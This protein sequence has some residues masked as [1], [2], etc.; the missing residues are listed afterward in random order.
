[1]QVNTR[2]LYAFAQSGCAGG[3]SVCETLC[4]VLCVWCSACGALQRSHLWHTRALR[5]EM[6]PAHYAVTA[7][8]N[9]LYTAA[10]TDR[11]L[12]NGLYTSMYSRDPM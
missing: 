2:C 7:A 11:Y 9:T 10:A 12:Q 8:A 4:A 3:R 1:M 6:P 5:V